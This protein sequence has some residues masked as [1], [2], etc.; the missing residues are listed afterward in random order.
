V[1]RAHASKLL[2]GGTCRVSRRGR[3]KGMVVRGVAR[4]SGVNWFPGG[5]GARFRRPESVGP[6]LTLDAPHTCA[7]ELASTILEL[8]RRR[9]RRASGLWRATYESTQRKRVNPATIR[10]ADFWYRGQTGSFTDSGRELPQDRERRRPQASSSQEAWRWLAQGGLRQRLCSDSRASAAVRPVGHDADHA[11]LHPAC[12]PSGR[13]ITNKRVSSSI[14]LGRQGELD[15]GLPRGPH[16]GRAVLHAWRAGVWV[17]TGLIGSMVEIRKHCFRHQFDLRR[18]A[19]FRP[20]AR[21][22]QAVHVSGRDAGTAA[23][24]GSD[25]PTPAG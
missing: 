17:L 20:S 2:E 12:R 16:R 21:W 10:Y 13:C 23:G 6:A 8:D 18:A 15:P 7:R 11:A 19:A 3:R 4:P 24:A 1:R 25:E 5:R 22:S 9:A 14:L